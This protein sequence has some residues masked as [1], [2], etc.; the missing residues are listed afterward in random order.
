MVVRAYDYVLDYITTYISDNTQTILH[1][2]FLTKYLTC[3]VHVMKTLPP[4][5]TLSGLLSSV[6]AL[7]VLLFYT[8]QK[9]KKQDN[10][11]CIDERRSYL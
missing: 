7:L 3:L 8:Y 2:I 10:H 9:T 4:W 6:L 1:Q 11:D 5:V